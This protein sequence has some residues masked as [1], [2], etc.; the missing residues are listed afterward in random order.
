M[1]NDIGVIGL[2]VMGENLALNFESRGYNVSV[3]NRSSDKT[4]LFMEKKANGKRIKGTYSLKEFVKSLERP[5]KIMMMVKAGNPVDATIDSL[6]PLLNKGDIII[7]GGNSN[8]ED[9]IRRIEK[10]EKRGKLYLGV[11]VS[12]GEEGALKGPSIMPGGSAQA[13]PLVKDMLQKISAKVENNEPCCN[14]IGSSGSGHFVKTVH[15]GIEYGDMQLITEIYDIM[16]KVYGFDY[17]KMNKI[18]KDWNKGVLDS[19]LIEITADIMAKLDS[20]GEPLVEKILD[21]AG[22]KGTG[23]WTGILAL[24]SFVPLNLIVE[25][26][27]ARYIS[28]Q[29]DKRDIASKEFNLPALKK[30]EFSNEEDEV[31]AIDKLA[32]ALFAAKIISYTQG[33]D[34]I[35]SVGKANNWG[36]NLSNIALLWRGGCIIRS[37]FLN[38]ISQAYLENK[39]LESLILDPYFK[40]I[41]LDN[42]QS[43]RDVVILANT[44]K[45]AVPS[46]SAA[47]NWFDSIRSN[48]LPANLLQAQ[49]DYFGAHTYERVDEER[50]K[51][52]HTRWN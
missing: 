35:Q 5:R 2:A 28:S 18:F 40:K 12:G 43:L 42:E 20:D 51:F 41:I 6:L 49:R 30:I 4:Q 21:V 8:Y 39:N 31:V 29:K 10:V 32:K 38:N 3:Y 33:F 36:L 16:R 34:L 47:L 27:F 52:F 48:D 7:D 19:F 1:K 50:G 25:A 26:V 24:E 37:K 17:S 9:T 22:Q 46:L 15:N 45:V 23:K 13:W 11:G 44:H 14:W